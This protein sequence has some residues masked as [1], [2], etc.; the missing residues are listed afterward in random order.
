MAF[1]VGSDEQW[2]CVAAACAL[3]A[4]AVA[5]AVVAVVAAAVL[6]LRL[7]VLALA[8]KRPAGAATLLHWPEPGK[9]RPHM[10]EE[11]VSE[12]S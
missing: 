5:V 10:A 9:Q 6:A 2:Q 4:G 3:L 8:Q 11:A 7:A 12:L 1:L